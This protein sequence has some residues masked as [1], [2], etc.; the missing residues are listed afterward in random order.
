M[1]VDP[2]LTNNN[3]GASFN[4][5]VYANNSPYKYIDPDGRQVI[6]ITGKRPTTPAGNPFDSPVGL[7]PTTNVKMPNTP[8]MAVLACIGLPVLCAMSANFEKPKKNSGANDNTS[9]GP[10]PP[11]DDDKQRRDTS[12]DNN[13]KSE[14]K[15]P[16][17]DKQGKQIGRQ[18]EKDL[19]KETRKDFHDMKEKGAP[20]RTLDQL[21]ADALDLYNQAGVEP[22][23]WMK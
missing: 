4:R 6:V 3:T 18:I 19:G 21:K 9:D 2:V 17:S 5:Y 1:S 16:A 22:P 13:R 8:S 20:D 15:Q 10:P 23:S 7:S 14:G 12:R 11:D